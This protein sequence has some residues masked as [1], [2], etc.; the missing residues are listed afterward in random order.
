MKEFIPRKF[1]ALKDEFGLDDIGASG[2][3]FTV[4]SL[5][6]GKVYEEENPAFISTHESGIVI[7][8]NSCWW[9]VGTK[10]FNEQFKEIDAEKRKERD[11]EEQQIKIKEFVK[12]IEMRLKSIP[13]AELPMALEILE[14]FINKL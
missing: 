5:V 6:K 11:R 7:D 4:Q 8:D 14:D 9:H 3:T 12:A 1:V 10:P 13:A 2:L